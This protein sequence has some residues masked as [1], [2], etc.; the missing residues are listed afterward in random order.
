M[1]YK[2]TRIP[3]PCMLHLSDKNRARKD[4]IITELENSGYL[5][6]HDNPDDTAIVVVPL[7]VKSPSGIIPEAVTFVWT[8]INPDNND[9]EFYNKE[10]L[11]DCSENA[12]MFLYIAAMSDTSDY[13]QLFIMNEDADTLENNCGHYVKCESHDWEFDF[14]SWNQDDDL[15]PDNFHKATLEEILNY[16]NYDSE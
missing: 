5:R 7:V 6:W 4:E 8:T 15:R 2:R 10:K 12:N 11:I 3:H 13:G 14:W 16:Y 9:Y 1:A